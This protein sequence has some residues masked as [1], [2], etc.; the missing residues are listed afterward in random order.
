MPIMTFRLVDFH[1]DLQEESI[2]IHFWT[3]HLSG[4][5]QRGDFCPKFVC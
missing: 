5:L 1:I 3:P 2:Y 4:V